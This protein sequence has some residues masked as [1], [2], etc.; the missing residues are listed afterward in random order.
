MSLKIWFLLI[1]LLLAAG[2]TACS[3]SDRN[4]AGDLGQHGNRCQFLLLVDGQYVP[5]IVTYGQ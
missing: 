4:T 2:L 3:D 5:I 1:S